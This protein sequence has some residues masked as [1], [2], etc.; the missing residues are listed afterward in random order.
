[1]S[2]TGINIRK[3]DLTDSFPDEVAFQDSFSK[4]LQELWLDNSRKGF[5]YIIYNNNIAIGYLMYDDHSWIRGFYIASNYRGHGYGTLLLKHCCE[6]IAD[7]VIKV[8]ITRG[9]EKLYINEGFTI[10]GP[11]KDFD[12]L[13]IAFKGKLSTTDYNE[14]RHKLNIK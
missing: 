4:E 10:M 12:N 2:F 3:Y 14:L 1:M 9:A 7:K 8:N 11:R 6:D 13:L 5:I